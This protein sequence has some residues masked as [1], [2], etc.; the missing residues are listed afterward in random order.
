MRLPLPAN[1]ED[2][3]HRARRQAEA[4]TSS[5]DRRGILVDLTD[6]GA[7]IVDEAVTAATASEQRL[8]AGL[9]PD[10]R[11]T[12]ASLLRKLL[13]DLEPNASA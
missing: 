12:L 8:L 11:E 9:S 1:R 5:N 7:R 2:P 6:E 3:C 4:T 10:E 13:A